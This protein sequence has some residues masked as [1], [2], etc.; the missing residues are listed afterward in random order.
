MARPATYPSEPRQEETIIFTSF[1]VAIL[2]LTVY[3][4][5][6]VHLSPNF[7]GVMLSVTLF[8]YFFVLRFAGKRKGLDQ[9]EAAT[10]C[11]FSPKGQAWGRV[12]PA[13]HEQQVGR[14]AQPVVL[15][16]H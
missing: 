9:I 10:S 11:N 8:R 16:H 4:I 3:Q 15:H 5:Y 1:I 6:L 2:V 7:T 13:G 12:H 14:L